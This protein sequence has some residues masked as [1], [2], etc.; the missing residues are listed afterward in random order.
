LI[1]LSNTGKILNH[2]LL[3]NSEQII[4]V[5]MAAFNDS[6]SPPSVLKCEKDGIL[7]LSVINGNTLSE[8]P[9]DSFPITINPLEGSCFE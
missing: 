7:I 2:Y 6:A 1:F 8:I 5:A 9:F 3:L 4:E